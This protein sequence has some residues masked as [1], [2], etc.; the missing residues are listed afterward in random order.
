MAMGS[1]LGGLKVPLTLVAKISFEGT[2]SLYLAP[3]CEDVGA[4]GKLQASFLPK[5]DLSQ[6]NL[7]GRE[8]EWGR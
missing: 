6:R 8:F 1:E 4:A 3:T 2:D 7:L 5:D